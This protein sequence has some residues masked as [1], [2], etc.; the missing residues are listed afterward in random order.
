MSWFFCRFGL[1]K[2]ARSYTKGTSSLTAAAS[3]WSGRSITSCAPPTR[4]DLL[5]TLEKRV[6]AYNAATTGVVEMF[7]QSAFMTIRP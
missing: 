3:L 4:P 6:D 1:H 2:G 7:G 5:E